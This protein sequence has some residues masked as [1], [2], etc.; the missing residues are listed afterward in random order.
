[1]ITSDCKEVI[2]KSSH[3][4]KI[5][6]LLVTTINRDN[7]YHQAELFFQFKERGSKL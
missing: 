1:M 7:I 6:L 5:P 4:I 3:P 2:N